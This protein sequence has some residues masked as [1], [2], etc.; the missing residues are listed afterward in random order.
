MI[1]IA[2]RQGETGDAKARVCLVALVHVDDHRGHAFECAR[3]RQRPTVDGA[4]GDEPSREVERELLRL[5]VISAHE[6]VLLG[7]RLGEVRGGERVQP[8]GDG[9]IELVL[10]PLG[11]GRRLAAS[12]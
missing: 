2:G 8:G 9:R 1:E 3:A 11:D 4:A 6:R 12:A 5:G 10:D 7:G